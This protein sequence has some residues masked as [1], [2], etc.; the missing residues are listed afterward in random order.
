MFF[1]DGKHLSSG[2]SHPYYVDLNAF[3]RK[4]FEP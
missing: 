4:G 1:R 2:L 3:I